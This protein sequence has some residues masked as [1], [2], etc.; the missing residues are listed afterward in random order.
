MKYTIKDY[1]NYQEKIL[2]KTGQYVSILQ[3]AKACKAVEKRSV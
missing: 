2:L 1:K 3:V